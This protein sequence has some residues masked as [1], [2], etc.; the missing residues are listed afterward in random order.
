MASTYNIPD[1]YN[2]DS[3]DQ[4]TINFFTTSAD[5]GNEIDLTNATP[6]M[7]IRRNSERGELV[8]TLTI[9]DGLEWIDQTDGEIRTSEFII[10]WGSGLFYYD[11]QLTY[12]GGAVKTYIR[13][14]I[15]V[16]ED[17]TD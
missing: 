13:G 9:G 8:K 17:V 4:L 15:Q 1:Q 6:K 7:Q 11:F 5:V 12:T 3:F 10:D 2:G 16:I 14:K